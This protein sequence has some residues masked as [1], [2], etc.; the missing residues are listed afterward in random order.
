MVPVVAAKKTPVVSAHCPRA[1]QPATR[2]GPYRS[3]SEPPRVGPSTRGASLARMYSA[4]ASGSCVSRN[5]NT[6]SAMMVSQ[7]P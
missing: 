4:G 7:S 3:A 2:P 5:R 6:A 1:D